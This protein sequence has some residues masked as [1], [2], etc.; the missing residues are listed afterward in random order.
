MMAIFML[1]SLIL[2]HLVLYFYIFISDLGKS[3]NTLYNKTKKNNK[4]NY[5]LR[6][7]IGLFRQN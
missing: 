4:L 7:Q 1:C 2:L 5:R 3:K 6:L